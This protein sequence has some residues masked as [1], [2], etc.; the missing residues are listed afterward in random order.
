MSKF[1][2]GLIAGNFDIIHPGYTHMFNYISQ[3]VNTIWVLQ[4][5]NNMQNRPNKIKP[6][7]SEKEREQTLL[8]LKPV[9]NVIHYS[10]EEELKTILTNLKI[11]HPQNH[12][13]RFLGDDYKSKHF[14]SIPNETIHFIPRN[15]NWSTTKFK[16]LIKDSITHSQYNFTPHFTKLC[17]TYSPTNSKHTL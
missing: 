13:I 14:T 5:N 6:I 1:T 16:H 10:N 12:F 11:I 2:I 15:H 7:L 4:D 3:H 17:P 8:L 9:S